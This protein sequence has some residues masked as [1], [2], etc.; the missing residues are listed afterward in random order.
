MPTMGR[1]FRGNS[2]SFIAGLLSIGITLFLLRK[3]SQSWK[4]ALHYALVAAISI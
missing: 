2:G 3:I 1:S 4:V